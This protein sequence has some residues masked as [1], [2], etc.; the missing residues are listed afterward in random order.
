MKCLW[1]MLSVQFF[2]PNFVQVSVLMAFCF[3]VDVC[4]VVSECHIYVIHDPCMVGVLFCGNHW[5]LKVMEGC[6]LDSSLS[7]VERV[8]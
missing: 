3:W 5:P 8:T 6:K 1:R 2:C 7:W 4:V